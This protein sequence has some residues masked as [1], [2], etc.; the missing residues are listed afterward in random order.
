MQPT[1]VRLEDRARRFAVVLLALAT[2][3]VSGAAGSA[4]L[5]DH[6]RTTTVHSA[7]SPRPPES[8]QPSGAEAECRQAIQLEGF[9]C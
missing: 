7:A 4:W 8:G 2:G 1:I 3:L 6:P 9:V 5:N